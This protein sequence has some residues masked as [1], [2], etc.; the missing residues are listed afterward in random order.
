MSKYEVISGPY[1][2][3]F[4]LNT[5]NGGPQITPYLDTFHAVLIDS[6]ILET[7]ESCP[8]ESCSR[9]AEMKNNFS[10]KKSFPCNPEFLCVI[11]FNIKKNCSLLLLPI[12]HA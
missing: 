9:K 6:D 12:L 8:I 3:A 7:A 4:E 10:K 11:M 1:F 5:G 2:P